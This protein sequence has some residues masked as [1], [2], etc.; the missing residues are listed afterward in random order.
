MVDH[1]WLIDVLHNVRQYAVYHRIDALLP[2]MD[3]ACE[4][5]DKEMAP[6]QIALVPAHGGADAFVFVATPSCSATKQTS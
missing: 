4:V 5:T 1:T 2:L 3:A 6:K